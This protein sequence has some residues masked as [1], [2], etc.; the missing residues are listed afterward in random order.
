ME[1]PKPLSC[2]WIIS[3]LSSIA[4]PSLETVTISIHLD[5]AEEIDALELSA[6]DA[7]FLN[8]PLSDD[9]TKLR[10]YVC[11]SGVD[12]KVVL[13]ALKDDGKKRVEFV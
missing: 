9:S 7:L 3:I 12:R 1:P 2:G 6:L 4:L 8:Q 10:F 13:A 11:F 5:H